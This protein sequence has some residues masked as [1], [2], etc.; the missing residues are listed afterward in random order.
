METLTENLLEE[1]AVVDMLCDGCQ[2]EIE[3]GSH[4]FVDFED[5]QVYCSLCSG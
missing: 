4:Y 5:G 1:E 2:L 3:T